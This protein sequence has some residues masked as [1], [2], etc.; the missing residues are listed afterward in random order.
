MVEFLFVARY[1]RSEALRREIKNGL[2]GPWPLV[3]QVRV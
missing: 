2:Q 3:P 1:L